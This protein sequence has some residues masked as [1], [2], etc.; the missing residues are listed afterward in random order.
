MVEIKRGDIFWANLEPSRG[1]EQ[2]GIRPVLIIQNDVFNIYSPTTIIAPFTSK[3][4]SK[5]YLTS[6]FLSKQILKMN[7]ESKKHK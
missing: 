2:G 4:P 1:S 5:K 6:I 3:K 7:K